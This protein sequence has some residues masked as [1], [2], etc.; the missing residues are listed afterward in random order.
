MCGFKAIGDALKS[1]AEP[2]R[3]LAINDITNFSR[4]GKISAKSKSDLLIMQNP[5]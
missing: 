5:V 3:N 4:C 2:A 1:N